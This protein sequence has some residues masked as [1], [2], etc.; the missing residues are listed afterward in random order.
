[1]PWKE[2]TQL[3]IDAYRKND[4]PAMYVRMPGRGHQPHGPADMNAAA[5][6][7]REYA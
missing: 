5:D 7:I 1:V 3:L 6:F 2:N 4:V